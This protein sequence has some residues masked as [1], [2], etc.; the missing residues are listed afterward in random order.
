MS[1]CRPN[2][3]RFEPPFMII[4]DAYKMRF[5]VSGLEP[6]DVIERFVVRQV[7]GETPIPLFYDE[8]SGIE[9]RLELRTLHYENDEGVLGEQT[10]ST[11]QNNDGSFVFEYIPIP[12]N[13]SPYLTFSLGLRHGFAGYLQI[14][15]EGLEDFIVT[16]KDTI[17]GRPFPQQGEYVMV[18]CPDRD[19][20]GQDD[21][22]CGGTD[23]DDQD[24][25]PEA[26]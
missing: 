13:F 16:G 15:F 17:T 14:S 4:G 2:Y 26:I 12:N 11:Y 24:P 18:L 20:D 25:Y 22:R 8:S 6:G 7:I 10:Y 23:P 3:L 5:D 1:G 9:G 21:E 19:N